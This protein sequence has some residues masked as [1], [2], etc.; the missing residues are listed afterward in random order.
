MG[1][2]INIGRT[3]SCKNCGEILKTEYNILKLLF[4]IN[5]D[6]IIKKC[7][8]CGHKYITNNMEFFNATNKK[9]Y[10]LF[11]ISLIY[12]IIILFISIS[13][14]TLYT[15]F[16]FEILL[17][18]II[19]FVP[20]YFLLLKGKWKKEIKKSIIRINNTEYLIDLVH[21]KILDLNSIKSLY[22]NKFLKEQIY[23]EVLSYFLG[24]IN[25]VN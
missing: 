20:I 1:V 25:G 17:L 14:I 24:V 6:Y 16:P 15:N 12:W 3:Y 23:T 5:F 2:K 22:D 18:I 19:I 8:N 4:P 10:S 21:S 11:F 7:P 9:F 13:L